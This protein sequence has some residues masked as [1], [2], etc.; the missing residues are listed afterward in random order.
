MAQAAALLD[1]ASLP[2]SGASA[3]ASSSAA[4]THI[5]AQ[6]APSEKPENFPVWNTATFRRSFPQRWAEYLRANF[7]SAYAVH[8]A[9]PGVDEKT[10]RDWWNGKRD[11]SGSFVAV[12]VSRDPNAI[13]ILGAVA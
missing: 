8:K 5:K 9:F 7:A 6:T 1:L 3:S 12:A 10:C 2:V 13:K 11:P 4:L